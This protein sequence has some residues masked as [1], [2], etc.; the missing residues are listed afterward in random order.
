MSAETV[1]F[2]DGK[3]EGKLL[4]PAGTP[5]AGMIVIQEWWGLVPHVEDVASRFA[6]EGYLALA[7]DLYHGKSTVDAE[8]ANHLMAGL[9]W[10]LAVQEL[11]SA[12]DYLRSQ[13]CAKVGV[14]GFCMG[15]ALSCLAAANA[16][17]DA[18]VAFYGF[19]PD[20]SVMETDCPPTQ[21]FFGESED[22]FD[23]GA[24]QAWAAKQA[25]Q[26][27]D[28]GVTVFPGAGHAFFNDTRPEAY[29]EASAKQAW[30]TTLAHFN[31]HLG[32]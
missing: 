21:I 12:V 28:S 8:E 27:K 25:E 19:P 18:A 32:V 10:P 31:K 29:H 5:R 17:V 7:P 4:R 11:S 16:T 30:T 23:V 1:K 6:A 24:A 2:L 13:G 26:G 9:D 22:F 20:A 3:A 14:V 15:G